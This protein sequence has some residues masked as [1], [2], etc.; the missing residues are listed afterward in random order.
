VTGTRDARRDEGAPARQLL[1]C[2]RLVFPDPAGAGEVEVASPFPADF[3]AIL[4]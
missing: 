1:H 2:A 3:T 4:P